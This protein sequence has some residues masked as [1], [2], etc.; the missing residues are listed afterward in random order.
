MQAPD[1]IVWDECH[2]I[3]AG[4]WSSIFARYSRARHVGLSATPVRLDGKGLGDHFDEMVRGPTVRELIDGGFLVRYRAFAPTIP[5]TAG[6]H[7]RMGDYV[8]SEVANLMDRPRIVGDAIA[9]YRKLAAGKRAVVFA[10]S[11]EASR[12]VVDGFRAAGIPAE[13]VDGETPT[14]ER[15]AAIRRFES[16][17]TLVLSN[18]DLFGEGF[19]LPSIEVAILLRPT[20]SLGLYL[21]QVG[22]ALRTAPGKSEAIILDHAGNILRHGLPDEDREWTLDGER[23]SK[24]KKESAASVRQCLQCY[25]ISPSAAQ[26]CRQCGSPFPVQAREIEEVAGDLSEVD[27]LQLRRQAKREQAQS[28]SLEALIELGRARGY[29]RPHLWASHVWQS[30]QRRA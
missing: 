7:T 29:K 6:L 18:V 30:R 24:K 25:G 10:V 17:D 4:S 16:G 23:A 20:Q 8:K 11:I 5:D 27:P 21:Q 13:H 3:A 28:Q 26:V 12:R 22:R 15:D 9:H 19:D 1:L 2:H 14:D